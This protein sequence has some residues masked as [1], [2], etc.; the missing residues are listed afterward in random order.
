MTTTT[1][2]LQ[3]APRDSVPLEAIALVTAVGV[4]V[5]VGVD[6]GDALAVV[7]F[8]AVESVLSRVEADVSCCYYHSC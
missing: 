3:K 6:V 8:A 5:D 4:D 7:V 1:T 2:S